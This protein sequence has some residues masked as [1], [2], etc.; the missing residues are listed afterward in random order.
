MSARSLEDG[1]PSGEG[2]RQEISRGIGP[3][4]AVAGRGVAKPLPGPVPGPGGNDG[5]VTGQALQRSH[6]VEPEI[7]IK[8][9]LKVVEEDERRA[10]RQEVIENLRCPERP[11]LPGQ[12]LKGAGQLQVDVDERGAGLSG[13]LAQDAGLP[14]TARSDY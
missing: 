9:H 10:G 8:Q 11:L 1:S 5:S 4:L 3:I 12:S 14:G 7:G 2:D 13:Q 6:R